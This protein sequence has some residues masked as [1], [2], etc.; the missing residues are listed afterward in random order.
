MNNMVPDTVKQIGEIQQ[1]TEEQIQEYLRCESDAVH[2]AETYVKITDI[3][4]GLVQFDPYDYQRTMISNYQNNRFNINLLSRQSGKT[5]AVAVFAIWHVLFHDRKSVLIMANKLKT[6]KDILDRIKKIYENLPR[7]LQIGISEWNKFNIELEN[8]SVIATSTTTA[9]AGRSGSIS[10]LILDEF[11]FV[12]NTIASQFWQS[13]YPTIT[14][15]TESKVIIISTANGMNLFYKM[16]MDATNERSDFV[17]FEVHWQDVPGRDEE[18][19]KQTI[20]NMGGNEDDFR[21]EYENEFIGTS[22]TLLP[23]STI[24][25]LV[26][27]DVIEKTDEYSIYE[28]PQ[29]DHLYFGFVDVSRGIGNDF[30]TI[31][32]IDITEYPH[33]QVAVYRNNTISPIVF[34]KVI[35]EWAKSYNFAY[36]LLEANDSGEGVGNVLRDELEYENIVQVSHQGRA[37]QRLGGGY[38][39][40]VR[41][42]V[43]TSVRT[44]NIGC[45]ALREVIEN[46]RLIIRDYMTIQ[47]FSTFVAKKSSYQADEGMTDDLIMPLVIYGWAIQEPYFKDLTNQ[48]IRTELEDE[49]D[50]TLLSSIPPFGFIDDGVDSRMDPNSGFEDLGERFIF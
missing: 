5:T 35:M 18:W 22:Q 49:L 3:D 29:P 28:K 45:Q 14:S 44:K 50:E 27:E 30:S 7:W 36:I 39:R 37:G 13:S 16:W 32:M 34:P 20:A 8:Q 4:Q 17:P 2:F 23:I 1:L 11:A 19:K 41:S 15:G 25:R 46:N 47:E 48:N 43:M 21:Q 12:K 24:K 6:A 10:L 31:Q 40:L 38:S 9:D 26:F 42:G 33:K